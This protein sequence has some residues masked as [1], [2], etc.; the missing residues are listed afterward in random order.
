MKISLLFISTLF[1]V[2]T[3]SQPVKSIDSLV[4]IIDAT[5]STDSITI[6]KSPNVATKP[7]QVTAFLKGDTLLK[8]IARFRNTS[9][10]RF[11]Y[12]EHIQKD[13]ATPLYV[14]DVDTLTNEVLIEVYGKDNDH[15]K[16]TISKP[17][18]EQETIY[19]SLVLQNSNFSGEIGFALVDRQAAK[20][21]FRGRLVKAVPLTPGCGIFAWA[22]VQ[23]F[24]II[25]TTFPG[26]DKKHVLI[27]QPC[28]EFLKKD[29]FRKG[30]IYDVDVATNSGVTFSYVMHNNYEKDNLP[31]FWTREIRKSD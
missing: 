20:Y 5:Y 23:K 9:R 22:I 16:S 13:Y 14:K 11:T 10:L 7:F 26:Y 8:T 6:L 30:N 3:F 24:E 2:S 21:K 1:Y 4:Q 31:T 25:S 19:P 27:I 15:I 28:P 17:L 29:F 12:Y 18:D